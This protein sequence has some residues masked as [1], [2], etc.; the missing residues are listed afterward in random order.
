VLDW[1]VQ[2]HLHLVPGL[3]GKLAGTDLYGRAAPKQAPKSPPRRVTT[4][5]R[6]LFFEISKKSDCMFDRR[7]EILLTPPQ[8]YFQPER[9]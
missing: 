4:R 7:A 2:I 3:T 5:Q 6:R 1:L 9:I 8:R